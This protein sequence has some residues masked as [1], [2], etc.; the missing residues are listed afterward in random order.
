MSEEILRQT[1]NRVDPSTCKVSRE[2]EHQE[3]SNEE[4]LRQIT[5]RVD[6]DGESLR[7]SAD[8]TGMR[9]ITPPFYKEKVCP[10]C[11]E[12]SGAA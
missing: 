8:I 6:F 3:A 11:D 4:A 9:E 10:A 5:N 12:I 1:A 7:R 2:N